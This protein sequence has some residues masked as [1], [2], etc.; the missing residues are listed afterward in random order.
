VARNDIVIDMPTYREALA[1]HAQILEAMNQPGIDPQ[2]KAAAI[3]LLI[4]IDEFL[5]TF[6][7]AENS[8]RPSSFACYWKPKK[9]ITK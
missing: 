6:Q 9:T 1:R 4:Q 7:V 3:G 8:Q 2:E 5:S